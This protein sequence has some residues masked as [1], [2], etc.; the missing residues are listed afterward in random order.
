MRDI[1]HRVVELPCPVEEAWDHVLD[2]SWLGDDGEVD[3]H[4]GGEGWVRDG[5]DTKFLLVEE[6]IDEERFVYRWASFVD[7]P[8][9]VEIEFSP[10]SEG[11]RIEIIESPLQ[12]SMRASLA[13][14]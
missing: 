2:P 5:D 13:L 9:R 6:V 10:I 1:L 12:A 4:E 7:E 8:S 11:T 3:V 14:R